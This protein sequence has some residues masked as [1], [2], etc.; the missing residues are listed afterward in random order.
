MYHY[1]N[2]PDKTQ[3]PVK[4]KRKKALE[5]C[6]GFDVSKAADGYTVATWL[7]TWYELYV[8]P[9]VPTA[10]ANRYELMVETYA[11]PRIGDVKLKVDHPAPAK[12]IQR[13]SHAAR[14]K[15]DEAAGHVRQREKAGQ[16]TSTSCPAL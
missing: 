2:V 11:I 7:S 5:K 15:Q 3:G 4:K 6:Q 9:N 1:K 10:T 8:K 16:E 13:S 12:A 14:Q